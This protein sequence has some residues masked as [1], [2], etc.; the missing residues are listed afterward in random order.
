MKNRS[1]RNP[2][3]LLAIVAGRSISSAASGACQPAAADF[4]SPGHEPGWRLDTLQ[5]RVRA[6]S[7]SSNSVPTCRVVVLEMF[8]QDAKSGKACGATV[9]VH[10]DGRQI[11]GCGE[12]MVERSLDSR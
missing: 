10:L 4:R 9:N 8:C 2:C 1:L 5:R 7:V 12:P 6:A 3:C 11:T